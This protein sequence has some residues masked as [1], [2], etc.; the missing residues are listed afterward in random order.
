MNRHAAKTNG[1]GFGGLLAAVT[2]PVDGDLDCDANLLEE[3]CRHLMDVGCDGVALFGTT[4]EGPLFPADQRISALD[5]LIAAGI[6]SSKIV[7]SA[8]AMTLPD[9]AR[10]A[11]H[12]TDAGC[13]GV[14]LMPPFFFRIRS[15]LARLPN[16]SAFGPP[17]ILVHSTTI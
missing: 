4:G 5:H 14:L 16:N 6:P 17:L 2:T 11:R 9:I 12:A 1:S 13:A 10:L 3:R 7:V 15:V 8:S